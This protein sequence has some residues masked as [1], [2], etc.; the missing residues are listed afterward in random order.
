MTDTAPTAL[1]RG[2]VAGAEFDAALVEP[3]TTERCD[4]HLISPATH[5]DTLLGLC[6][7]IVNVP[8]GWV[9]ECDT[10]ES[11]ASSKR[12]VDSDDPQTTGGPAATDDAPLAEPDI[13][14]I[15]AISYAPQSSFTP[16]R[17]TTAA[18][19]PDRD[20]AGEFADELVERPLRPATTDT[21]LPTGQPAAA[22]S[23]TLGDD[24][25][26]LRTTDKVR[27]EVVF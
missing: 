4:K 26:V 3:T 23:T 14:R 15:Y 9:L 19:T 27:G 22:A 7:V 25:E 2:P 24:Y 6:D 5:D 8:V 12:L 13:A 20:P 17:Q 11:V 21:I 16:G 1:V 18:F 10:R